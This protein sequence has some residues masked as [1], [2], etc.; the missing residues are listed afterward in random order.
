MA[1]SERAEG[2]YFAKGDALHGRDT[3]NCCEDLQYKYIDRTG[4]TFWTCEKFSE[5]K[6]KAGYENISVNL[7]EFG[8]ETSYKDYKCRD[9]KDDT[10]KYCLQFLRDGI[11]WYELSKKP[12]NERAAIDRM[13]ADFEAGL[14][15]SPGNTEVYEK[16]G[17]DFLKKGGFDQAI[18]D[19]TKAI[20]LNPANT[21]LYRS[22][23]MAYFQKAESRL[24]NGISY[25]KTE[26]VFTGSNTFWVQK[27]YTA[28]SQI[29]EYAWA[30][31]D[32]N[33]V[34]KQNPNDVEVFL[35]RGRVYTR[36]DEYDKAITDFTEAIRLD[37]KNIMA[38]KCS[39]NAYSC[40]KN[41][42]L[43][44]RY[45]EN[46]LQLD[47]NDKDAASSLECAKNNKKEVNREHLKKK[48][49]LFLTIFGI[50]ASGIICSLVISSV[51]TDL[52]ALIMAGVGIIVGIIRCIF[53]EEVHIGIILLH[54]L[55]GGIGGG[56]V[57]AGASA[58]DAFIISI[59]GFVIGALIAFYVRRAY[60]SGRKSC[61]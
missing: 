33:H 58:G 7:A 15:D 9:D 27:Y 37:P 46:A 41:Y 11:C 8:V 14:K 54:G 34:L 29:K 57:S 40:K 16:R 50:L 24:S 55:I 31:D 21:E 42:D 36:N 28:Y 45:Y 10:L 53:W 30:M 48:I 17:S 4:E 39:G 47:P 5:W 43:A 60:A 18:A 23:G 1:F 52:F 12:K 3:S 61:P 25:Y 38:Y 49:G 22:R 59:A 2:Y 44:I 6:K 13:I 56:V 19:Y 26:E 51:S 20:K 35:F 32:F